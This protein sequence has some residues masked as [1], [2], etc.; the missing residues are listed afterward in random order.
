MASLELSFALQKLRSEYAAHTHE[1]RQF[2]EEILV[3]GDES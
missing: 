2:L 1:A 3:N